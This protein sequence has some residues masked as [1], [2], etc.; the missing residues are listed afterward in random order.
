MRI[1]AGMAWGVQTVT[2]NLQIFRYL[3]LSAGDFGEIW[4]N[5]ANAK[6][7]NH[8]KRPNSVAM[9][10]NAGYEFARGRFL[11][12]NYEKTY[13]TGIAHLHTIRGNWLRSKYREH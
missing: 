2:N 7:F 6:P 10:C 13:Y 5:P 8:S 9:P 12:E 11:F 1:T 3:F 4:R